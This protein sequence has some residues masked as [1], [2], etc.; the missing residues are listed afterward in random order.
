MCVFECAWKCL[1]TCVCVHICM[2]WYRT[3]VIDLCESPT[4]VLGTELCSSERAT[5]TFNPWAISLTPY[6]HSLNHYWVS[7]LLCW[8]LTGIYNLLMSHIHFPISHLFCSPLAPQDLASNALDPDIL[9]S[10]PVSLDFK[11][12]PMICLSYFILNRCFQY[13]QDKFT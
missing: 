8:T 11:L 13:Q 5:S 10:A 2:C 3:R 6:L 4:W 9:G 1:C 7:M 12:I